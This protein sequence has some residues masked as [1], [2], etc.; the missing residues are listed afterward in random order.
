MV[1]PLPIKHWI[2]LKTIGEG[3]YGSVSLARNLE[4]GRLFAVKS[5]TSKNEESLECLEREINIL[6]KLDSRFVIRYLG[7]GRDGEGKVNLFMEYME[8]GNLS[9]LSMRSNG[10]PEMAIKIYTASILRGL[11]YLHENGIIHCDVKGNNVL[12]GLLGEVKL[13]DF[14]AAKMVSREFPAI[15]AGTLRWMA[16]EIFKKREQGT[17]SDIWSLGCTVVEM[18]TGILPELS[19]NFTGISDSGVDFLEKCFRLEPSQRW[20]ASQLLHH[21]FLASASS[22]QI[23]F[24]PRTVLSESSE[25]YFPDDFWL[26]VLRKN[27]Q[28]TP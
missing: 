21:P 8:G 3:S 4:D 26:R 22:N 25:F 5:A 16:P 19:E 18:A 28:L 15:H 6:K 2:R 24:S 14:G 20:T 10:L 13:A 11:E 1:A 27:K 7:Q 9:S 12:F 23:L 17:A